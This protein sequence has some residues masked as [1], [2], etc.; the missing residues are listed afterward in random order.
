MICT[1]VVF[2]CLREHFE[3]VY[4]LTK[5][6]SRASRDPDSRKKTTFDFGK[7]GIGFPSHVTVSMTLVVDVFVLNTLKGF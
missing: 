7:P 6:G 4:I 2:E 1:S 3:P 5:P